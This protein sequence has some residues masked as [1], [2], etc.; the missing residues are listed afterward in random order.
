[1]HAH[2]AHNVIAFFVWAS[3]LF[4]RNNLLW[5][6][7][8]PLVSY[9]MKRSISREYPEDIP[10]WTLPLRHISEIVVNAMRQG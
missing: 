9:F 1:M 7:L 2:K 5:L 10:V 4:R 3:A 8:F 6:K